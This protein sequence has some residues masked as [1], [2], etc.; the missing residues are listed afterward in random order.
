MKVVCSYLLFTVAMFSVANTSGA[1]INIRHSF[2]FGGDVMVKPDYTDGTSDAVT[3][4]DGEHTEFGFEL[5]TPFFG[6]DDLTTELSFGYK[7][8]MEYAIN[9]EAEFDRYSA[10][11]LQLLQQDQPTYR[12]RDYQT[13]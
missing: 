4:G 5:Q 6:N 11:L 13:L 10:T 3:A 1:N 8:D 9:V 12:H 7:Y 2:D